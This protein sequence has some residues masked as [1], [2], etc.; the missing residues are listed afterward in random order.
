MEGNAEK[1]GSAELRHWKAEGKEEAR[2]TSAKK[3]DQ[4]AREGGEFNS[5]RR[6]KERNFFQPNE[7]MGGKKKEPRGRRGQVW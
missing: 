7:R 6:G 5:L 3:T 4:P 2:L 1:I